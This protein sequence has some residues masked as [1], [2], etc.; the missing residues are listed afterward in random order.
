MDREKLFIR[1]LDEL[2]E[3]LASGDEYEILTASGLIRKLLFDEYKLADQVNQR[4]VK[5]RFRF[6]DTSQGFSASMIAMKPDFW[7]IVDGLDPE[8]LITNG[9]VI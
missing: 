5:F 4:R 9:E 6:T 2:Q 1:T 8:C 3:K 7:S